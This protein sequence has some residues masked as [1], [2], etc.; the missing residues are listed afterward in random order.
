[1]RRRRLPLCAGTRTPNPVNGATSPGPGGAD[2]NLHISKYRLREVA[3]GRTGHRAVKAL[4]IFLVGGLSVGCR[5]SVGS[6]VIHSARPSGQ[7]SMTETSQERALARPDALIVL[8]GESPIPCPSLTTILVLR[9][10]PVEKN[11]ATDPKRGPNGASSCNAVSRLLRES[12]AR[13]ARRLRRAVVCRDVRAVAP[14]GH[15]TCRRARSRQGSVGP[16]C[17]SHRCG[18]T[19]RVGGYRRRVG[20]RQSA[21]SHARA[22]DQRL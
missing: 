16:R 5:W 19:A 6:K 11:P 21:S 13:R 15:H 12:R 9:G 17:P 4:L 2:Q 1:M 20:R 3:W 22:S 10:G 18:P 7:A 8:T 14:A